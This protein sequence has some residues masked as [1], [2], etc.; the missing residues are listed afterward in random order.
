MIKK[1]FTIGWIILLPLLGFSQSEVLTIFKSG[2]WA[3]MDTSLKILS[4]YQYSEL[5]V[6]KNKYLLARI[7]GDYGLIDKNTNTIL[8][9]DYQDIRSS[10][11][12]YFIVKKQGL[13]GIRD[14]IGSAIIECLFDEILILDT[15]I[16]FLRNKNSW[17][18][19]RFSDKKQYNDFDKIEKTGNNLLLVKTN[20]ASFI[21]DYLKDIKSKEFEHI[22]K[23]SENLFFCTDTKGNKFVTTYNQDFKYTKTDSFYFNE[24]T[25]NLLVYK[26]Y[27]SLFIADK[28]TGKLASIKASKIFK[29]ISN[30]KQSGMASLFSEHFFEFEDNGKKGLLNANYTEI[31]KPEYDNISILGDH[32]LVKKNGKSGLFDSNGKL[33]IQAKYNSFKP[34]EGY[35]LVYDG[36]MCG[37]VDL[38]G[39]EI[40]P[41]HYQKVS[42]T[43]NRLFIVTDD[44][45]NGVVDTKNRI[46]LPIEYQLIKGLTN[47]F[48]LKNNGLYGWANGNGKIILQPKYEDIS[49][50]NPEYLLFK[51]NEKLGILDNNGRIVVDSQFDAII[52]TGNNNLY[53]VQ[54][55]SSG[56]FSA[57]EIQ[58]RFNKNVV[59]SGKN[60]RTGI[61]NVHGQI[62][63]DTEYYLPI[64]SIDYQTNTIIVEENSSVLVITFEENGKLIDKTSYKN[65]IAVKSSPKNNE[66]NIWVKGN[67]DKDFYYGLFTP[68]GSKLIDYR[69]KTIGQQFLNQQ[70]LVKVYGPG[71]KIGIVNQQTGK[72][73]LQ[74]VYKTIYTNDFKESTFGRCIKSNGRTILI[75][76]T[77]H[78]R[79][80]GIAFMDD[81]SLKYARINKGGSLTYKDDYTHKL[82]LDEEKHI[83]PKRK[84][85]QEERDIICDGGKWGVID[86]A[87]EWMITPQYQFIQ[88][89]ANGSFIAKKS[90]R[91]GVVNVNNQLL[92]DFKYDELRHFYDSAVAYW[93]G[94]P[95]YK[96]RIK[97]KWGVID[98][99][100]NII[101]P[102]EYDDIEHL[103]INNKTFFKTLIDRKKIMFGLVN[104]TGKLVVEPNYEFI[105][106]FKE[107]F[108]RVKLKQR[109]WKFINLQM[110]EL[111]D[112]CFF[113]VHD[114]SEGLAA[115]KTNKAWGFINGEG[116]IAI[117]PQYLE[118]GD[119]H[120][121][122]AKA[123]IYMPA[124]LF[125]LI[126]SKRVFALIDKNEKVL[127]NTKSKYCSDVSNGQLVIKKGRNYQIINTKGQKILPASYPEII[128]NLHYGLYAVK[129]KKKEFAL[130]NYKSALI[131]PF[132]KYKKFSEF[133]E[134]L[135]FVSGKNSGF[136]DT[137]G[138]M[139]IALEC[140][141]TKNFHEGLAA[142]KLQDGW[143]Y[144]DKEGNMPIP[145]QFNQAWDFNDGIA[146]V[147]DKDY[148]NYYINRKGERVNLTSM[149]S[150]EDFRIFN[151][152]GYYGIMASDGH[153]AVYPAARELGIFRQGFAPVGIR[154]RYGLYTS[155]GK[156]IAGNNYMKISVYQKE[157]IKL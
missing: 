132:G 83:V 119:F 88:S 130:Y 104:E 34:L 62:L 70:N 137:L 39:N 140:K 109:C 100:E 28:N 150:N 15:T 95:Y 52:P 87:G 141:E 143:G 153:I 46:V 107:G 20:L 124:K 155:D 59:A 66:K 69:Y 134:G 149:A 63:L 111:P 29:P 17:S 14:C 136:I 127:L 12:D 50:L 67:R 61:I 101:I 6:V 122:V 133:S 154:K 75:D 91:W 27:D 35:W 138:E 147:Q 151:E 123:K 10:F 94:I 110:K 36:A 113:D 33:L 125:G 16:A 78:I 97:N 49:E 26:A 58:K 131:V 82:Y 51:K 57:E 37:V 8:P 106:R 139:K 43:F 65:Y 40:I 30:S 142:I 64:I 128:E 146:K 152:G 23:K 38:N 45:K 72:I 41:P 2:K 21:F 76:S 9:F 71:G 81:F 74:D 79:E 42:P 117:A 56:H 102:A 96:F 11:G 92:V 115:V 108:S 129:N 93:A 144:I 116:K 73:L 99:K 112:D 145:A 13:N 18:F 25:T 77:A 103:K 7:S 90:N 5:K 135:C 48:L 44:G 32:F 98:T 85:N 68:K 80:K 84:E 4:P 19:F 53:F 121:G 1:C 118:T 157:F 31:V 3:V 114:F 22:E 60:F 47:G 105:G 86:S 89:C 126:K 54:S 156:K 148:R 55:F 24:L 120:E